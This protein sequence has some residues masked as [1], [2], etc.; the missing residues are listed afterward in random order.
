MLDVR[1]LLL[2]CDLD[3]LGTIA[4]VAHARS[5]T[6]S[7]VSQQLSA[8]EREAG[9][10]LLERTGRRVAFTAAGQVLVRH[11]SR[12]LGAMEETEAAL[13][14]VRSGPAGPLRIGAFPTAVRTLLP[15]ALVGLG[16]EHPALELMVTELDPADVPAALRERR[17]DVG[18]LNDYDVAPGDVDA[19]LDSVPLLDETVFLAVP[20]GS[21]CASLAGA[22]DQPWI[23]AS[24]GTLCHEVTL[25]VC[26]AQGYTPRVRHC[27]DDFA[28]V[29]ALVGAGQGVSLVPEL[30]AADPPPSVRLLPLPL[31]RRTRIAHRRGAAAH[32]GVA[33]LIAALTGGG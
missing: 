4:A 25:R 24:A 1:K 9:V 2:L 28:T 26:A 23:V 31:R 33:A 7:A 3:R 15:A 19:D 22:A 10:A 5:Y 17:L 11:A 20:A 16:R 6:P 21:G 29:L 18:L 27:A 8:L 32:P 30:A 12:V 13:A 14:A